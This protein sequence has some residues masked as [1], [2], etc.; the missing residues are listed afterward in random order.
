MGITGTDVAKKASDIIILDDNF[1]SIVR[2]VMWGR[3]VYDSIRKFLQFQLSVNVAALFVAYIG[4]VVNSRSPLA[5]IQLLWVNLIMDT[6]AAL[7]LATEVP[8]LELL[9]RKP[10]GRFDS[11]V[12]HRMWFSILGH[13]IFQVTILLIMLFL[14]DRIFV[15]KEDADRDDILNTMVFNAFVFFQLFN[16]INCRRLDTKLDVFS[17]M[18]SNM[19]FPIIWIITALLQALIVEFGGQFFKTISLSP[20]R[21]FGSLGIGFLSIPFGMLIKSIPLPSDPPGRSVPVK[22]SLGQDEGLEL[23]THAVDHGDVRV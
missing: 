2:S 21:F 6:L 10:Y 13:S 18:F 20:Q 8:S 7:A 17:G 23:K 5:P 14:G 19:L 22:E 1:A 11:L 12:N 3:N 16:E 4:A 9:D 15:D